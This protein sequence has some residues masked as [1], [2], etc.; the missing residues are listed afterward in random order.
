MPWQ[1]NACQR[2][3]AAQLERQLDSSSVIFS[4]LIYLRRR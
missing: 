3:P 2:A 4:L 1:R